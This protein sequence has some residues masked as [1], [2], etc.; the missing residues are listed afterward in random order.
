M[1]A[2]GFGI[3]TFDA[4]KEIQFTQ[5]MAP[6]EIFLLLR[7]Y[8]KR[9]LRD[10]LKSPEIF[11]KLSQVWESFAEKRSLCGKTQASMKQT[12]FG[13]TT[14]ETSAPWTLG[15]VEKDTTI[16]PRQ[17]GTGVFPCL[18][19]QAQLCPQLCPHLSEVSF[20]V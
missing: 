5:R 16:R 6:F 4:G 2:L 8:G 9:S 11:G 3:W 12:V 15:V 17:V 1:H 20:R 19:H 7:F 18:S 14:G 13:E 10:F